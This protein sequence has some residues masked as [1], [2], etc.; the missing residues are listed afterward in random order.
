MSQNYLCLFHDLL[1]TV[2]NLVRGLK[3]N[4][5]IVLGKAGSQFEQRVCRIEKI[6]LDKNIDFSTA[7]AM[8]LPVGCLG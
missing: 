3:L 8:T 7:D 5:N 2:I 4:S 1:S 6:A